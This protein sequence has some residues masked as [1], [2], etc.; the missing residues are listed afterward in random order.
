MSENAE[1]VEKTEKT[2]KIDIVQ[3]VDQKNIIKC[4]ELLYRLMISQLFYDGHQSLAVGLSAVA[5]AD[6]P[7]PPSDRLLHVVLVGL[8]NEPDRQHKS[9]VVTT[10]GQEATLGPGLGTGTQILVYD[11]WVIVE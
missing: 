5:Q 11:R 3:S 6:P 10:A 4:R 7:C 8:Q 9:T 1:K 2:E